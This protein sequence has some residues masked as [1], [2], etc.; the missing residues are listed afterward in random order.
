M[1]FKSLGLAGLLTLGAFTVS[2][3]TYW[4]TDANL[5]CG[6]Y[7]DAN[8]KPLQL[9]SGVYVCYVYGTLPWYASG[10]GWSSSI[11]VS[12]PPTAPVAYI[13]EFGGANGGAATL[14]YRYQ[15]DSTVYAGTSASSALYANQP[16]EVDILGLHS[17]APAYG[18]E[19]DGPVVVLAE[20]PDASTCA[21]VQAQLIY[22]ALPGHPWS[23]SVP[24]VWDPQTSQAWSTV[25][26][27]DGSTD[28]VSFAIYNLDTDGQAP[29]SYT[30]NVYDSTGKRFGT[31]TTPSVP[32]YGS[33]GAMLRDVVTSV[34][35]GAFKLQVAGPT[36]TVFEALQF[37]GAS[38]TT[39]V[40]RSETITPTPVTSTALSKRRR[41][42][43][44]ALQLA[45]P[46]IPQ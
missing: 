44:E 36:E 39:L 13:L 21:Q 23:L 28:L 37:H 3:Q 10:G 18:P 16:L 8:G 14:D 34:P 2:A 25:G 40:T 11:R 32:L 46:R 42:A 5:A 6:A 26:V 12:A 15:G 27:D 19:T 4:S 17:Q 41:L 38:A 9:D 24:V 20:C 30:I 22:S 31:A 45:P 43:P 33:Y 35:P 7:G 29:H 1:P